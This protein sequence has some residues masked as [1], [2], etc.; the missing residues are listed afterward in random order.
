[1]QELGFNYRITD[2]QCAL[3]LSQIR[4]LDEFVARRGAIVSRYREELGGDE[5]LTVPALRPEV[6]PAW[7]IFPL[8]LRLE[9]LRV[10]RGE[11]FKALRERGLGV[12]VHYIPTHLQPYFRKHF[13][14]A[15]G[16]F[17]KAE[18]WYAAEISLPLFPRMTDEDAEDVIG[19]V[20][21]VV[22]EVRA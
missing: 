1:M 20:K 19:I 3:G 12:Q 18:A 15:P 16:D 9:N 8:R 10:G 22:N 14:H 2:F 17:P 4:R 5:A 21:D 7:H 6:S 13:G 11:V